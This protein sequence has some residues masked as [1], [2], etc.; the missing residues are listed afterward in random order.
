MS[1]KAESLKRVEEAAYKF[2]QDYGGCPQAVLSAFKKIYG[3]ISDDLFR[4]ATG[5]AGGIGL[6]GDTCGALS[7]AVL[8]VS[9]MRGRDYDNLEDKE[10]ARTEAYKMARELH[11]RFIEEYGSTC[12]YDIQTK[13]T[14]R[15]FNLWDKEDREAFELAGGHDDKC[16]SVCG[17]AARW[18]LE[19]LQ[20][21]D[22]LE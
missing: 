8:A 6:S 13:L 22:L 16:P 19:L 21:R 17:K 1:N 4:A 10:R 20:D 9:V 11:D 15:S 14:G 12:C 7:G 3:N 2:E 18:A 5:M